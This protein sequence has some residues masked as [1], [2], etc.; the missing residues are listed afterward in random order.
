MGEFKKFKV[1]KLTFID[2]TGMTPQQWVGFRFTGI[3]GSDVSSIL[4]LNPYANITQL[5]FEKIGY[6]DPEDL[7]RNAAVLWG[8]VDEDAILNM[9]QYYDFDVSDSTEYVY[10]YRNQIKV[11]NIIKL[12]YI[13]KHDDY[14]WLIIN[15]DGISVN[16]QISQNEVDMGIQELGK[17]ATVHNV[18]ETKTISSFTADQW[19]QGVPIGYVG[20]TMTYEIP[21]KELFPDI[22]GHIWSKKDGRDFEGHMVPWNDTLYKTIV[23]EC[24]EFWEV[25][26]EGRSILEAG[27]TVSQTDHLLDSLAP[28]PKNKTPNY[29]KFLNQKLNDKK[30]NTIAC[31]PEI[32]EKGLKEWAAHRNEAEYKAMKTEMSASI[33]EFMDIND[34]KVLDA[35][36]DKG[37]ISFN[38][39]LYVKVK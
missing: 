29:E 15:L 13:I 38:K 23:S 16:M 39:K 7:S 34:A 26:K 24:E 3:G 12:N 27:H 32:Y 33:K 20:Q 4:D 35:G 5:F 9:A 22:G 18:E 21:F 17:L 31:P 11:R 6:R 25:C 28:R 36:Q 19:E 37:K 2:K 14:P 30:A 8:E 1:G 10:N